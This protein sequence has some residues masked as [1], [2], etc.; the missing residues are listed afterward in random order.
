MSGLFGIFRDF[1]RLE[2]DRL[3][4]RQMLIRDRDDMYE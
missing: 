3:V 4:L 1:P 2:T